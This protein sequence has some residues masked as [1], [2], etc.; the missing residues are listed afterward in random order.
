MNQ[1]DNQ[2]RRTSIGKA[3]ASLLL[4]SFGLGCLAFLIAIDR[5]DWFALRPA[6]GAAL[7]MASAS[8]KHA[9]NGMEHTHADATG[10]FHM[11]QKNEGS[12][13]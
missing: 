6:S 7:A 11:V 2:D 1:S 4:L 5:A 13:N 8:D 10:A 9:D 3:A 12:A